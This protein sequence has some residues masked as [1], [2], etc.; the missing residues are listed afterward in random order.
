MSSIFNEEQD[1]TEYT[2]STEARLTVMAE[3]INAFLDYPLTG[4]GAGQ[5]KNYNPPGRR[6]PWRETHNALIQVAAE[7][8]IAGLLV[9]AFSSCAV[10]SPRRAPGGCSRRRGRNRWP[11]RCA[12]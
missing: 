8:G 10:P 3:G 6:E 12:S 7:T 1:R 5:F 9:F 2:G 11:T 4:L